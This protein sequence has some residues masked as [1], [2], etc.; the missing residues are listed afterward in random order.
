[1]KQGQ[2]KYSTRFFT[3]H[4]FYFMRFQVYRRFQKPIYK[5]VVTNKNNRV[6]STLGYYN[7]FKIRFRSNYRELLQPEFSAKLLVIDRQQTLIWLCRGV[8]PTR[9][10]SCLLN[11]MGL[12]KTQLSSRHF[13]MVNFK[14]RINKFLPML[15]GELYQDKN[16]F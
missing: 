11:N 3:P 4:T 1:M 6:V 13:E 2:Q 14:S 7:P 15:L 8:V 5:I 9:S 12:L 10:L 16:N